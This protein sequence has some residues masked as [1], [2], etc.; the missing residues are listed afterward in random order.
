MRK[1]LLVVDMLVKVGKK[2]GAK[3]LLEPHY[4]HTG[5]IIY[6]SGRRRYF[7]GSCMDINNMG[8]SEISKDKDYAGFFMGEMGYPIPQGQ[9]FLSNEFSLSLG[10]RKKAG[11][12]YKYAQKIGFPVIVKPNSKSQGVG[13]VKVFNKI[14]LNKALKFAF[15]KDRV[16][17]VQ[18][19][20]SGKDYRIVVLDK[21][22]ISAYQRIPLYVI[23]D[24]KSSIKK[25]VEKKQVFFKEIDR[26][27]IIKPDDFRFIMKLGREKLTMDS[28]L[29]KGEKVSLLD[30]ANLST[31]G[32]SLDVTHTMHSSWKKI[33]INL[34]R[35][36]GLRFCG[37]DI[38]IDGDIQENASKTKYKVIEINSAPG[39]D[40]YAAIGN[41]QKMH[42][43]SLYLELLKAME[44]DETIY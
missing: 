34:T 28:I 6:K 33:A 22:V 10:K 18:E 11:E 43:E 25:L 9:S 30:N 5:Q 40:H 39:L 13:V 24:G 2:I 15:T 32:D 7:R 21:K 20:L 12:E 31:G 1:K 16:V 4:R 3:V 41:K 14:E 17:L 37:V 23:G 42:V 44:K 8:S 38:I 27:T 19:Y 36:M 29:K 35:D 26:D